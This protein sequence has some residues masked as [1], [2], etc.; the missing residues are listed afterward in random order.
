[1][2]VFRP[3]NSDESN[4]FTVRCSFSWTS[5]P[6]DGTV[7]CDQSSS[8]DNSSLE[9]PTFNN[10][11]QNF[12]VTLTGTGYINIEY[13]KSFTTHP[14]IFAMVRSA[15]ASNA[16]TDGDALT[17]CVS[18][19][20]TLSIASGTTNATVGFRNESGAL[21]NPPSGFELILVGPI[22]VGVTTGNSN[23][24]WSIGSGND[25]NTVYSYLNV[26][27]NTGSP[28]YA[29]EVAGAA[30]F[31]NNISAKTA[32][33]NPTTAESGTTFTLDA[34]GNTIAILLPTPVAGLKYKFIVKDTGSNDITITSTSDGTNAANISYAN[35]VIAGDAYSVTT[36]AD[37]LTLGDGANNHTIGD[38][39]ECECDG[40]NWWWS[41]TIIVASSATLA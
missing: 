35:L 2:S 4:L 39:V 12:K 19:Q 24:G 5:A 26:G 10:L 25:P 7:L 6:A 20:G 15:S 21:T 1:M 13:G 36:V 18:K 14:T 9:T 28:G 31:R 37:V 8:S 34:S 22:K 17:P 11:P 30:T 3:L 23:K 32:N 41:G 27:I 16:T 33:F 29:L 38:Y 40:T